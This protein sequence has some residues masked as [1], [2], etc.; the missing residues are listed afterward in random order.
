M[1]RVAAILTVRVVPAAEA[2]ERLMSETEVKNPPSRALLYVM[3]G[4][5]ALLAVL[6]V[7]VLA[8]RALTVRGL[9]SQIE[10]QRKEAVETQRQALAS[11]A[12]TMLRLAALPL[13]WAVRTEMIKE[14]FDQID[15][16]FRL[17]VKE[18]GVNRIL[19]VDENERVRVATD[20]KLEGQ[21]AASLVPA[22]VLQATN[23]VLEESGDSIHMAVPVMAFDSRIG[24]M[25][26]DY[27]PRDAAGAPAPAP[28]AKTPQE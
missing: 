21:P 1:L 2:G 7:G 24:V 6:L 11:Q 23:V 13:G 12:G 8:W 14:N 27:S 5:L 18:P 4:A 22:S 19:L 20:R 16:Y 28:P 10:T 15:D 25:V 9:E 3:G 26:L 17:F